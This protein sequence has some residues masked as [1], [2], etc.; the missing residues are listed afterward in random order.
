[1][2]AFITYAGLTLFFGI[3]LYAGLH[4]LQQLRIES[5]QTFNIAPLVIY[6]TLFPVLLGALL[7][8]PRFIK[9]VQA[10]FFGFNWAKFAAIAVPALYVTFAPLLALTEWA[11]QIPFFTQITPFNGSA[12]TIAGMIAG[13]VLLDS[14][15]L[16]K[17][18]EHPDSMSKR[19]A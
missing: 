3:I 19:T 13:Y 14:F 18:P 17:A 15:I 7:R 10:G 1:M 16:R 12:I 4:Q 2:K 9:D 8:I 6:T 5:Q 11:H